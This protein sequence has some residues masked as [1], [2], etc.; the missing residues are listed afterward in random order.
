[1]QQRGKTKRCDERD[2]RFYASAIPKST[3][4]LSRDPGDLANR[5]TMKFKAGKKRAWDALPWKKVPAPTFLPGQDIGCDDAAL[6][7]LEVSVH[8]TADAVGCLPLNS[9]AFRR[10]WM[11]TCS[12]AASPRPAPTWVSKRQT[13]RTPL[14]RAK[15]RLTRLL[16][17]P[18]SARTRPLTRR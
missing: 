5:L 2:V 8:E 15:R 17:R 1:M 12:P 13:N 16:P 7:E 11:G 9:D 6:L 10:K 3:G 4:P 14:N 18:R